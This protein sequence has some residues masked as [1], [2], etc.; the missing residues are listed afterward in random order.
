MAEW[1][2]DYLVASRESTSAGLKAVS[3]VG[4]KAASKVGY[5][6]DMSESSMADWMAAKRVALTA[7]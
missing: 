3:L 4:L 6:A 5:S 2:A 1:L 7:D